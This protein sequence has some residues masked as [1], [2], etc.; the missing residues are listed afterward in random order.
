MIVTKED[1]LKRGH[2]LGMH[3]DRLCPE[4]DDCFNER[5]T[6]YLHLC[7]QLLSD[8]DGTRTDQFRAFVENEA[9]KSR[10]ER[11]GIFLNHPA[12]MVGDFLNMDHSSPEFQMLCYRSALIK[13]NH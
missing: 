12:Y 3:S 11:F 1:V 9:K 7:V 13:W 6:H 8:I 5:L 2:E 4:C 10:A